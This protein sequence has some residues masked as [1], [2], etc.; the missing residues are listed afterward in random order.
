MP[1]FLS[2]EEIASGV[3]FWAIKDT[4]L[5]SDNPQARQTIPAGAFG[6]KYRPAQSGFSLATVSLPSSPPSGVK[7]NTCLLYT[8]DAADE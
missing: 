7:N 8:S 3:L 1:E 2:S 4:Q 6:F 5:M